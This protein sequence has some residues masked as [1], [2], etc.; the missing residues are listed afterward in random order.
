VRAHVIPLV[1]VLVGSSSVSAQ[2]AQIDAIMKPW[3]GKATPG[4]AVAVV[5]AG[6]VSFS[7]GYGMADL[8]R[9]VAIT[10]ETVFDIASTSKQFT[11][12]TILMLAAAGKLKLDDPIRTYLPEIPA[13][14]KAP[15]TIRHLLHHTGGLRDYTTLLGLAGTR[16]ADVATVKEALAALARQRGVMFEPGARYEYSNTGYFL[17]AQIAER[18]G[19]RSLRE[20]IGDQI[21]KPLAMTRS[22][23][24][25]DHAR[26]IPG[27]ALAYAPDK[28]GGW[29]TAMS[30]WEQ[31]GDGSVQTT[32]LDLARWDGNFYNPKVGGTALV[33][34]LQARGKTADGK[35]LD[36][37]AGLVL[38]TYRDQ[39]VVSHS[40]G[41]A[42]YRAQLMRFPRLKATM[43]VLCNAGSADPTG[44]ARSIADVVLAKQLA[45][46]AGKPATPA[47][48]PAVK[49][50]PAELDAWVGTYRESKSSELVTVKRDGEALAV[51]ASGETYPLVPLGSGRFRVGPT[52]IVAEFGGTAPKRTIAVK[53][54]PD[55]SYV[56]IAPYK[57]AA[58]ELAGYAGRYWSPEIATMWTVR[59]DGT[60]VVV[61]GRGL[62]AGKLDPTSKD[63]AGSS[64]EGFS[65]KLVRGPR[66]VTGF[67]CDAGNVRGIVFERLP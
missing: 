41:W 65:I 4:C 7:K 52:T 10:P 31:T 27:R 14:T 20:Q 44:L 40:G 48:Q 58:G 46:L 51:E 5:Q 29:H 43:I 34:A 47:Q 8:E 6:K 11:A 36:Y 12:A 61:D 18:A 3:T 67:T 45:P 13:L 50:A 33:E 64:K 2:P 39:P 54:P 22:Q 19:K 42:G 26:I 24:L 63:E 37:G 25:D 23:I 16:N 35:E 32:V 49:V 15:V 55:E 66:G 28:A 53:G 17:L 1:L 57:P 56:E 30:Q 9:G 21:F 38:G 60:Q 62:D 59:V